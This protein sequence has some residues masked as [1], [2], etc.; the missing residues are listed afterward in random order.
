MVTVMVTGRLKQQ[1]VPVRWVLPPHTE[2]Q[3]PL[4]HLRKERTPEMLP[5]DDDNIPADSPEGPHPPPALVQHL[6]LLHVTRRV[7]SAFL[8]LALFSHRCRG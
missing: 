4:K 1:R 7:A 3:A 2:L 5:S 8:L 6:T